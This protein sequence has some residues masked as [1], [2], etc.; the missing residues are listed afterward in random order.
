MSITFA[1]FIY[2][3]NLIQCVF[4]INIRIKRIMVFFRVSI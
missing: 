4:H 3:F 1:E 2:T